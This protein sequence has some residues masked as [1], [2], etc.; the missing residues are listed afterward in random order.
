M[1]SL[2]RQAERRR[3]LAERRRLLAASER[4]GR[5]RSWWIAQ[6]D[7]ATE[8]VNALTTEMAAAAAKLDALEAEPAE[9]PA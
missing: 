3:L 2:W 9:T 1:T 4:I 5:R 7:A 6:R 8:R